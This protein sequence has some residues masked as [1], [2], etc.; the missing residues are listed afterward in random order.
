[1]PVVRQQRGQGVG[2]SSGSWIRN[3]LPLPGPALW[4]S[5]VQLDEAAHQGQVDPQA[6]VLRSRAL[7]TVRVGRA[8]MRGEETQGSA[9]SASPLKTG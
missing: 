4:A 2:S 5:A 7:L 8:L 1:V 9:G 6:A 3:R